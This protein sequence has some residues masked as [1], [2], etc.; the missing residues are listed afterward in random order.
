MR[1]AERVILTGTICARAGQHGESVLFISRPRSYPLPC[2][3][4]AE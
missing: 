2:V 4:A 1:R 3:P